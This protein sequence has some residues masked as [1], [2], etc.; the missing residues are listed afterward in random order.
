SASVVATAMI[1]NFI[2]LQYLPT[3]FSIFKEFS[4]SLDSLTDAGCVA[5]VIGH[6]LIV[7]VVAGLASE[8]SVAV[9]TEDQFLVFAGDRLATIGAD[10][11]TV[12]IFDS[13][14]GHVAR[15][16]EVAG[17]VKLADSS[18]DIE[19]VLVQIEMKNFDSWIGLEEKFSE[20][21]PHFDLVQRS[22]DFLHLLDFGEAT[23]LV[24]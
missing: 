1:L 3:D 13:L 23:G 15:L 10:I 7:V 18:N 14:V 5:I 4:T 19:V 16:T 11:F 17:I 21:I 24:R 9:W 22:Q 8:V 2:S 20:S 6:Q 12:V